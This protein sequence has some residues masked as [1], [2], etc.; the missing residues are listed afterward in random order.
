MTEDPTKI[1]FEENRKQLAKKCCSL[2]GTKSNNRD[3]NILI[4]NGFLSAVSRPLLQTKN[5]HCRHSQKQSHS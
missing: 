1:N 3:I 4:S 5:K 2:F